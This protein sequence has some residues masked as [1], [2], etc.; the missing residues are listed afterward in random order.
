MYS[1]ILDILFFIVLSFIFGE[2]FL[3]WNSVS[4]YCF[5]LPTV[6][7]YIYIYL[8]ISF[9]C[10]MVKIIIKLKLKLTQRWGLFLYYIHT[11]KYL[12]KIYVVN[13]LTIW[14]DATKFVL[15]SVFT[16]IETIWPKMLAKPCPWMKKFH[17]WLTRVACSIARF[18]WR[19]SRVFAW[20]P[21]CL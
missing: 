10:V 11:K 20:A 21:Y 6:L 14:L 8:Y 3:C 18:V 7:L 13:F 9:C 16:L 2:Q 19:A 15:L 5:P 4:P 1:Y 12:P 17:F